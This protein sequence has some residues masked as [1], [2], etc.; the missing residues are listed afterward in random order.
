VANRRRRDP[1]ASRITVIAGIDHTTSSIAPE[2]SQSG[3]YTAF[4]LPRRN[5]QAKAMVA[6]MTNRTYASADA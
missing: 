5:H 4:L 3:R 1:G 6:T 2:Y